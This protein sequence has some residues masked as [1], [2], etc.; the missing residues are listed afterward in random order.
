MKNMLSGKQNALARMKNGLVALASMLAFAVL[1]FMPTQALATTYSATVTPTMENASVGYVSYHDASGAASATISGV[2]GPFTIDEFAKTADRW[3]DPSS[4]NGYLV[5]FV[6]PADNYLLTG[7]GANGNGD[8]YSV[9][10]TDYGN[11]RNYPG[12]ND[13]VKQA[14]DAGYV[15]FFGYSRTQSNASNVNAEFTVKGEQPTFALAASSNKTSDVKPGDELTFTLTAT[16]ATSVN[17]KTLTTESVKLNSVTVNGQTITNVTLTRQDDGTYQGTL[18]YTATAEDCASGS[19]S[20]SAEAAITYGYALGVKDT[21]GVTGTI[22]T[23][24]TITTT[25]S[26]TC[27]IADN[28]GVSYTFTG[29]VPSG[30]TAPTDSNRYYEGQSVTVLAADPKTV[31]NSE[32]YYT[33]DGWTLNGTSVKEGSTETIPE[34]GLIFV[35]H[36]T[37]HTNPTLT[38]TKSVAGNFGDKTQQFGFTLSLTDDYG[39]AYADASAMGLTNE[40][41]G[42]YSFSL[43]DGDHISIVIP[44]GYSYR[45]TEN[46][47][48]AG[49]TGTAKYTTTISGAGSTSGRTAT[50]SNLTANASVTYTNTKDVTPDVGVNLG[51]SAPYVAGLLAIGVAAFGFFKNRIHESR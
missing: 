6:K 44:Y 43:S 5:F 39:N 24:A 34:G 37:K 18:P 7:L 28:Y 25:A 22:N 32:G 13:L 3:W 30:V 26:T 23:E 15:G 48:D 12:I 50:G 38:I 40:G 49:S 4:Y 45:I 17:G 11:L 20:L 29:D 10:A 27:K 46:D 2:T 21:T 8:I 36:W 51:S 33:F 1:M 16:P 14:R 35:G 47:P 42:T 31:R 41:N 9:K 19:V